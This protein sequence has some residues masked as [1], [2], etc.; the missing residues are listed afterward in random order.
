MATSTADEYPTL[1]AQFD[2]YLKCYEDIEKSDLPTNS[3]ELQACII[4]FSYLFIHKY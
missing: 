4:F 1:S 3:D 2:E